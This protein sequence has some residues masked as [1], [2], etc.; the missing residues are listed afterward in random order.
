[1]KENIGSKF[2]RNISELLIAEFSLSKIIFRL[3][4][5]STQNIFLYLIVLDESSL[6]LCSD[7]PVLKQ[8]D[9]SPENKS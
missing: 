7:I 1:M 5:I 8:E 4:A 9:I 3:S 2:I 6:K